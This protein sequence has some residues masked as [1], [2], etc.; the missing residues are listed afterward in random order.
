MGRDEDPPEH[1]VAIIR[2]IDSLSACLP[3]IRY[4]HERLDGTG[5]PVGL[6]GSDI[7]VDARI[8]AVADAFDA[9][10]SD[11]PIGPS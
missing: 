6:S 4:H 2:H 8:I 11:R 7:P 5:Y 1:G 3:G 10:T 9:M